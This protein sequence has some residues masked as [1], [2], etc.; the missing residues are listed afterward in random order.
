MSYAA[1]LPILGG[2][3]ITASHGGGRDLLLTEPTD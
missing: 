2:T 1:L 3:P